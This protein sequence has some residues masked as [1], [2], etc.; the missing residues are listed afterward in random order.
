MPSSSSKFTNAEELLVKLGLG[1]LSSSHPKFVVA[2]AVS[3]LCIVFF[4]LIN[5]T[6]PPCLPLFV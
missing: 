1:I 4:H 3:W 2:V 6:H 5:L